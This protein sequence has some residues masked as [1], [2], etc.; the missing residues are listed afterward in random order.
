MN[1]EK[2]FLDDFFFFNDFLN[3]SSP[4]IYISQ[5]FGFYDY[6]AFEYEG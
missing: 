2:T 1:T 4:R 5:P 3:S 6:K